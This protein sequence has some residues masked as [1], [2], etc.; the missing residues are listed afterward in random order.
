MAQDNATWV[1]DVYV[2]DPDSGNDIGVSIYKDVVS[3]GMFGVDSSYIEQVDDV[4]WNPL[5]KS[6]TQIHCGEPVYVKGE[7]YPHGYRILLVN[8]SDMHAKVLYEAG[9]DPL[10]SSGIVPE[11]DGEP[12]SQ[13]ERWCTEQAA[14]FA[15]EAGVLLYRCFHGND[16]YTDADKSVTWEGHE[17]GLWL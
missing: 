17:Y 13:L 9:N 10:D 4:V 3:G 8:T 1:G 5:R 7:F 2:T 14:I 16:P 12:I 6:A 11:A 15:T